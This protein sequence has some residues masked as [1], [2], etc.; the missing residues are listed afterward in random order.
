MRAKLDGAEWI[1]GR[2][3]VGSQGVQVKHNRQLSDTSPLRMELGR[4]VLSACARIAAFFWIQSLVRD[5]A[6]RRMLV[7]LDAAIRQLSASDADGDAIKQ[8]GVYHNLLRQW[9][10]T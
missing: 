6:Q 10:D 5:E 7:Q 4:E 1:D 3:T 9:S 8:L 2:E